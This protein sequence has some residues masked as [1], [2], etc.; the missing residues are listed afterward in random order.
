MM[1]SHLFLI[2]HFHLFFHYFDPLALLGAMFS[3]RAEKL[4]VIAGKP[5]VLQCLNNKTDIKSTSRMTWKYNGKRLLQKFKDQ[6]YKG[7]TG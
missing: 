4:N 1:K 7:K 2:V 5:V 3:V 6:V